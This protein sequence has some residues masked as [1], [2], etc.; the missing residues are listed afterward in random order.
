VDW[1]AIDWI[2]HIRGSV[3]LP[4][5]QSSHEAFDRLDPLFRVRDTY[6]DRR[7]DELTFSKSNQAP[8]DKMATFDGGT[9]RIERD[10]TGAVLRFDLHSRIL[11]FCFLAP[12][13]FLAFAGLNIAIGVLDPPTAAERAEAKKKQEER[14]KRIAE[15]PL[16]PIDQFLGAP[17]PEKP[18]SE[19]EKAREKAEK[20]GKSEDVDEDEGEEGP[21]TTPAYVFAGIFAALYLGGRILEKWLITKRFRQHLWDEEP[22]LDG[23]AKPA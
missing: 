8:Q 9:L 22:A 14:M 12:L 20:K 13:L 15:Q 4:P 18:K 5:G 6:H 1:R 10:G 3:P 21:S 23:G 11:L 19:E 17:A 7:G 2:W 16:H